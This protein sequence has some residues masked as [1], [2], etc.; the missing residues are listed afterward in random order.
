MPLIGDS[1][2]RGR[3]SVSRMWRFSQ[4]RKDD[5]EY[6]IKIRAVNLKSYMKHRKERLKYTKEWCQKLTKWRDKHC[7][8]CKKLLHYNTKGNFCVRHR[9]KRK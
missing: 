5:S 6:R 7:L 8:F 1:I 2:R 3:G 9:F 4:R